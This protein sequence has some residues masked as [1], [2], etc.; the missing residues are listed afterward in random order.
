MDRIKGSGHVRRNAVHMTAPAEMHHA[1]K[2]LAPGEVAVG[3]EITLRPPHKSQRELLTHR[4]LTLDGDE[5]PLFRPRMQD[6]VE[7]ADAGRQPS[8]F[9]SMSIVVAGCDA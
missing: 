8:S 2:T 6:C 1:K 4:A 7:M 3:T 9:S 5:E